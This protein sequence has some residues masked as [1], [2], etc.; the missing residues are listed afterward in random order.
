MKGEEIGIGW[1]GAFSEIAAETE[2]D[3]TP[4]VVQD[5]RYRGLIITHLL[6]LLKNQGSGPLKD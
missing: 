2:V 4:L 5:R 3:L 1:Y 6:S